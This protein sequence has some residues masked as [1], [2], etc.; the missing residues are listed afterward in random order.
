MRNP[1]ADKPCHNCRRRRLKCDRTVPACHKC[2]RTGQECLGYGKLF[3]WTYGVASRGK[4][5]GRSYPMPARGPDQG[6]LLPPQRG[7][8]V[9]QPPLY[10]DTPLLDPILHSLDAHSRRYV[11]HFATNVAGDMVLSDSADQNPFRSLVPLCREHPILL[12]AIVANAAMHVSCLQ[13]HSLSG[14][15]HGVSPYA[16]D[17]SS[18]ARVDALSSKHR[19]LGLLRRA[20]DDVRSTDIDLI[21]TVIHLFIN[22]DLLDPG[23]GEW[24]AHAQGALRLI[25]YLQAL[26]RPYAS[27]LA[28]IR[29]SI[30]SDCLTF[31]VLGCTL[32]STS[33]LS[34][35]DPFHSPS[36]GEIIAAL[37]RAEATSYLSLP[38][39]LLQILFKACELS[40][41][42]SVGAMMSLTETT[43]Y[44]T[45][46]T[47]ATTL[48]RTAQSIDIHAWA[49]ALEA[50]TGP[51]TPNQDQNTAPS[52]RTQSRIHVALAHQNAVAIYICRSVDRIASLVPDTETLVTNVVR[53]LSAVGVDDPMF[54]GTSWPTF[55][56]G[57]E[58]DDPERRE[59]ALCRLREFW[60]LLPWGY[61]T[62]AVE[63]MVM[64]W[65][66][67]DMDRDGR[68]EGNWIQVLKGLGRYPLIA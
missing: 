57:V 40:N 35:S 60:N 13:K 7:Q 28:Q 34:L 66:V 36:P 44:A 21:V 59:W 16:S 26:E 4:M 64:T 14:A 51:T 27:P 11:Y 19:A 17:A 2:A 46:I 47:R 5:M 49:C 54:K 18:D 6:M 23:D 1:P 25:G 39:P 55:I 56:A 68:R 9:V 32:M 38:T 48:L 43:D 65:R 61:L 33:T 42:V 50:R 41:L 22:L 37:T 62:M 63:V 12:H 31:Y 53:H 8:A 10:I 58:T 24:A 52:P 30:T 15:A 45:L 67:R 20:L 29:D 3:I